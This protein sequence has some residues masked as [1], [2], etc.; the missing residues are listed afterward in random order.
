VGGNS[1]DYKE[2]LRQVA[3]EATIHFLRLELACVRLQKKYGFP[4]NEEKF[5]SIMN[6]DNDSP[7]ADQVIYR[8]SKAQDTVGAK[9]F[10]AFVL[11]Q[12]DDTERPFLDISNSLEKASVLMVADWIELCDLRNDISHNY[13]SN[14]E[15]T[16]KILN[17]IYEHKNELK[18]ILD[19]VV[20]VAGISLG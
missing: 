6:D 10:K 4:I 12:G 5:D 3:Q 14:T 19:A 8:F 20:R 2:K 17:D 1:L 9:L 7:L 18:N 11:S 16:L 15:Q 13:G